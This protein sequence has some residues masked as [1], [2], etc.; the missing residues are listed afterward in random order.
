MKTTLNVTLSI[1]SKY[2]QNMNEMEWKSTEHMQLVSHS[3][4]EYKKNVKITQPFLDATKGHFS[5]GT[6][7]RP[8]FH[9]PSLR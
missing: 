4:N 7:H 6:L 5:D 2:L 8:S 1:R 9:F 3:E